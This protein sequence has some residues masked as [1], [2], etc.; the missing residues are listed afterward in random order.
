MIERGSIWLADLGEQS[1]SAPGGRR[2]VVVMQSD[3]FNRSALATCVV[4]VI[5]TDTGLAEYPGNVF[6]P[7]PTSSLAHDSV[8]N[9]TQVVTADRGALLERLGALPAYLVEEVEQ[10]IRL[11]LKL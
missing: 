4:V 6:V 3:S 8:V 9:V 2:P 10:G 7:A 1:G 11:V 5:T